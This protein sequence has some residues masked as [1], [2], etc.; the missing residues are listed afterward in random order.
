M[1]VLETTEE[2]LFAA[3]E[4]WM[5]AEPSPGLEP[6]TFTTPLFMSRYHMSRVRANRMLVQWVAEGKIKPDRIGFVNAWG[7]QQRIAGYRFLNGETQNK[8]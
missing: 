5:A 2:E 8:R 1:N 6:G 7:W 4:T 3:I